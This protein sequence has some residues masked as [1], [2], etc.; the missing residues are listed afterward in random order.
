MLSAP[1]R[2]DVLFLGGLS[3]LSSHCQCSLTIQS[4]HARSF[5]SAVYLCPVDSGS[6]RMAEVSFTHMHSLALVV[7]DK[8]FEV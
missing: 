7:C 6:F 1:L 4:V 5:F 3:W 8:D 2:V